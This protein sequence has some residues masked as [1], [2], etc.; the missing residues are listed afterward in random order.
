MR[1][2]LVWAGVI[3][4]SFGLI[5]AFGAWRIR[6]SV[7]SKSGPVPTA[8]PQNGVEKSKIT[9]DK[10]KNFDVVIASPMTVSGITKPL[11]WVVISAEKIDYLTQSASDGSFSLNIEPVA[12]INHIK[13]TSINAQGNTSSQEILAVYSTS[14]REDTPEVSGD[15]K[16]TDVDKAVAFK[17]AQAQKPPK[18]YIG[19]ITDIMDS[20]IQ[21]KSV[22]SQIQQ[23]ATNK[24]DITVV[25]TKGGGSK[26]VKL[27]DIAIGDFVVAMG[28]IDGNDVLD[29]QRILITTASSGSEINIS[30]QKVDSVAKKSLTLTPAAGG[31]ILTITPDKD[32]QIKSFSDGK[33]KNI[34]ITDISESDL[35]IVV[36]DT[37]GTPSISRS[38]FYLEPK[39]E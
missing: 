39:E 13:A 2:E 15:A 12:G 11:T 1:K 10:P 22:D 19:T 30:M 31:E 20:T 21:I 6:S 37:T 16:D 9:I 7:V 8:T 28:Y 24:F 17:V 14:F 23:I 29:A 3:G 18:A 25:N 38:L 27:T 35:M 34:K 36:S 32:T 33:T 5:I 4:I 26:T